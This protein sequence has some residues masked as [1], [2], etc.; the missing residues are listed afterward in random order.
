MN[1]YWRNDPEIYSSSEI[2]Y[3]QMHTGTK[4]ET[5]INY[6]LALFPV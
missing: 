4:Y 6:S 2:V 5:N 1:I 3:I